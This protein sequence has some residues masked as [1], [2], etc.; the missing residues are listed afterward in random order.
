MFKLKRPNNHIAGGGYFTKYLELPVSLAWEVYGRTNGLNSYEE[1]LQKMQFFHKTNLEPNI[2]CI[3]LNEVFYLED[4]SW[5]SM[6]K[7][8]QNSIVRGKSYSSEKADGKYILDGLKLGE[9]FNQKQIGAYV[10]ESLEKYGKQISIKPRLGQNT[11][12]ALVTYA[13]KGKCAMTGESTLPVL[14][15]AHIRPFSEEGSSHSLNNGIL[16]RSDFHTLF[17]RGLVTITTQYKIEISSKIQSEW[18]NGKAYYRLHGESLQ[19]L[20]KNS[21][22]RPAPEMLRWHNENKFQP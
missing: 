18:F 21:N 8:W 2:G 13:Y 17:D 19:S 10:S 9:I 15:A 4:E 6:S 1:F 14:E 20:P 3:I 22:E 16:L 11:F 12:R 5:I 7:F